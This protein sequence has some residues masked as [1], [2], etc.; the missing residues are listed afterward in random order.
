MADDDFKLINE[1]V[2]PIAAVALLIGT[3]VGMSIFIV[4]TQMAAVAGPSIV[5]AIVLAIVP[6][7]LGILL[8]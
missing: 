6:M 4:P 3:A 1:Q 5:L 8:L 7:V 2:G